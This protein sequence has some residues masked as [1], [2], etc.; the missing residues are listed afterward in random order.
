MEQQAKFG[1]SWNQALLKAG[2]QSL[3]IDTLDLLWHQVDNAPQSLLLINMALASPNDFSIVQALR[4]SQPCLIL[5]TFSADPQKRAA[6]FNAGA[7]G[8]LPASDASVVVAH[9]QAL[10]RC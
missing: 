6:G 4:Q 10:L 7:N 5:L 9:V 1:H 8:I 2:Y 3:W